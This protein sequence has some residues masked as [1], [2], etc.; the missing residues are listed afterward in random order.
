VSTFTDIKWGEADAAWEDP[1]VFIRTF[2][3]LPQM[4]LLITEDYCVVTGEKGSGKTG[5]RIKIE[6]LIKK[7]HFGRAFVSTIDF[8]SGDFET[9]EDTLNALSSST[10]IDPQRLLRSYWEFLIVVEAARDLASAAPDFKRL[11]DELQT[12]EYTGVFLQSD[13]QPPTPTPT[14]GHYMRRLIEWACT[15]FEDASESRGHAQSVSDVLSFPLESDD[16][17]SLCRLLSEYLESSDTK[18]WVVLDGFDV[19]YGST[20]SEHIRNVFDSLLDTVLTFT[21]S[22]ASRDVLFIKALI[23]HDRMVAS[24]L[25]DRDKLRSRQLRIRWDPEKLQDF[26]RAKINDSLQTPY[27]DFATAWKQIMPPRVVNRTYGMEEPSFDYILRHTMWRPRHLQSH[28]QSLD[29]KVRQTERNTPIERLVELAVRESCERLAG[30]FMT[31][32]AIDHPHLEMLLS[33]FRRRTNIMPFSEFTNLIKDWLRETDETKRMTIPE[34]L[35]VLFKIGLFGAIESGDQNHPIADAHALRRRSGV[36]PYRCMFFYKMVEP[37]PGFPQ[38]TDTDEIAIHPIF[39][40]YCQM[41]PDPNRIV[42]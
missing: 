1:D 26:A 30:D 42:G 39:F 17:R 12:G 36:A 24:R 22:A 32:Y 14:L 13:E 18:V 21:T 10:A 6:S 20:S 38:L 34:T 16:Y 28:L 40:H 37:Q 5:L 27:R 8:K 9:F 41:K 25:R 11:L 3:D 15:I 31:E 33:R 4:N 7:G 29:A 2:I 35:R 19:F 23:P